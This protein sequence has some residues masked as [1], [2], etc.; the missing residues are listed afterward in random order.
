MFT[1]FSYQRATSFSHGST[2]TTAPLI[3]V[4]CIN[5]LD[6]DKNQDRFGWLP[7]SKNNTIYLDVKLKVV[8]R[9]HNRDFCLIE[10]LTRGE[11]D[12]NRSIRLRSQLVIV[13]VNFV[14]IE[15]LPP[16][17]IP[18]MFKD[19]DGQ[20]KLAHEVTDVVDRRKNCV[21]LLRYNMEKPDFT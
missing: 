18:K 8:E 5:Y 12:F 17:L 3:K 11:A 1:S 9:D 14:R 7:W 4:T 6:F 19:S 16:V 20:L 15:N 21:T 13:T 10:N 2:N